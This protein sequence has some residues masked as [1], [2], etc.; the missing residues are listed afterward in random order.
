MCLHITVIIS[1]SAAIQKFESR[2][3]DKWSECNAFAAELN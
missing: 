1:L 2:D 3:D